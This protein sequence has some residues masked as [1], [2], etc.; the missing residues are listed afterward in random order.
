MGAKPR[1]GALGLQDVEPR[2]ETQ[3]G[4]SGREAGMKCTG[5]AK[6][7]LVAIRM[8]VGGRELVFRRCSRCEANIWE[9]EEGAMSLDSVLNMA[10]AG[11]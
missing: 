1:I 5:C 4:D 8:R 10:R 11:R 3:S 7:S 2:A 9:N 6:A